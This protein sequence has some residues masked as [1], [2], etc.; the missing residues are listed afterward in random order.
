MGMP[1]FDN[2][3]LEAV[4][5]EA[6]RRNRWSFLVTAAPAAVPG[7]TGSVLNPIATF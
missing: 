6:A 7:A 2:L 1:I 3:D 5:R 4:S